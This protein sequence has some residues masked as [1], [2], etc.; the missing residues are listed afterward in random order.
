MKKIIILVLI[1]ILGVYYI[2]S[3]NN[4]NVEIKQEKIDVI[5]NVIVNNI[6]NNVSKIKVENVD[7][8]KE[9]KTIK[10][11]NII[12]DENLKNNDSDI[13]KT[14]TEIFVYSENN[15]FSD[16]NESILNINTDFID[17]EELEIEMDSMLSDFLFE[18]S[19]KEDLNPDDFSNLFG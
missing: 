18:F 16:K 5:S 4:S 7:V 2:Y 14:E 12:S 15:D 1:L 8:E 9:V 13:E 19:E 17:E 10:D 3:E 6:E 11:E